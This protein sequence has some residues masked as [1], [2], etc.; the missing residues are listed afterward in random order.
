MIGKLAQR[1]AKSDQIARDQLRSLMDELVER[2]LS[3]RPRLAP[4]NRSGLIVHALPLEINMLA[5][6]LHLELLQIRG[7]AFQ[8]VGVRHDAQRLRSEKVVVPN[9]KQPQ[10]HRQIF[11][12]RGGTEMLVH[13]VESAEQFPKSF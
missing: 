7:K 2:M 4:D 12:Q 5:V 10:Q 11:L 3:I 6:A 8:I 13:L 1:L 9:C